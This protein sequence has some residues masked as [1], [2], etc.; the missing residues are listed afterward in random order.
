MVIVHILLS[1][2]ITGRG[3]S[4]GVINHRDFRYLISMENRIPFHLDYVLA[5]M[6]HYQTIDHQVGTIFVRPYITHL[7][8]GMNVLG[9]VD[10]EVTIGQFNPIIVVT[11]RAIGLFIS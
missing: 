4:T 10:C 1:G 9:A 7:E 6:I 2:S 3:D 8:K 11:L 5:T